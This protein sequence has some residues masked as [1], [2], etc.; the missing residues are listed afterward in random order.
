M[1][2]WLFLDMDNYFASV[3]QQARPELRGRPVGILPVMSEGS[4][5]I[6][7]SYHAKR[8]GVKTGTRV[9]DARKL[10]PD[11]AFVAAR[12]DYYVKVHKEIL[13]AVDTVVPIDK[14]WSIDEMAVKLLGEEREPSAALA[15][16]RRVKR[17][18]AERVGE[19][20]TRHVIARP[21]AKMLSLFLG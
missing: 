18:V 7:A 9:Y 15:I 13:A 10:C 5:C 11:I 2:D 3:E 4:C 14:V 16:G 21:D 8:R 12:P 6:A 19:V 20:I 1:L 17:V